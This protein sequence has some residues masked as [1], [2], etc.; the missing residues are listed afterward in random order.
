MEPADP[1][2]ARSV[3]VPNSEIAVLSMDRAELRLPTAV[4]DGE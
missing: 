3:S 4:Q 1:K 2:M